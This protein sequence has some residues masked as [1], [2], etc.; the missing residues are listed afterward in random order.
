MEINRSRVLETLV[1]SR[2]GIVEPNPKSLL[3]ISNKGE[4]QCEVVQLADEAELKILGEIDWFTNNAASFRQALESM[5]Q[6]GVKNLKGYINS[7]G[8][9]AW[10]A[11]EIY[12][13]I[14]S[15]CNP[16]NRSLTLGAVCAS[17][18]T[19]IAG[20]FLK[21]NTRAYKNTVFMMHNHRV[22]IEGEEKDLLS[23]AKLL[24]NLDAEYR[25]RWASRM[26]ISEVVLKNK[27]DS[28]WWLT[29]DELVRYN[30]VS[31]F[32]DMEDAAPSNT[33][34]VFDK[35]KITNL[36]AVLNKSL[37][38]VRQDVTPVYSKDGVKIYGKA[39]VGQSQGEIFAR[40]QAES[41]IKKQ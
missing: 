13:L 21:E 28:T 2:P 33:A 25:K 10:E 30:V 9:S 7:P 32:I 19:T 16:E 22:G 40:M 20:A 15:F 6:N 5:K 34:L 24:S 23:Y 12:N 35:L 29:S 17:A 38:D 18:A 41:K 11:N 4:L 14:V 3:K 31:G 36:P 39:G 1:M 26:G 27:M 37:K 8:G